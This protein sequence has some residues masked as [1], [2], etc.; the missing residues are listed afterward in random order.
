MTNNWR[1]VPKFDSTRRERLEQFN[2]FDK[3]MRIVSATT[4]VTGA[5]VYEGEDL[6]P[7]NC[8]RPVVSLNVTGE[9]FDAFF[10]SPGG[11]RAQYLDDPEHGQAANNRLLRLL[12]PRLTAAIVEE[13]RESR[14]TRE[15]L[16]KAFLANSAK[17]WPNEEELDPLA[18]NIDLAVERWQQGCDCVVPK[19]AGLWAPEGSSLKVFGAFIDPY[20]NEIVSRKKILRR[21][22][23][24]ECG[25]S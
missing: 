22:D 7:S 24:H 17:I 25:F 9:A 20:G 4:Q 6:G 5:W 10:N 11:Y 18:L 2:T 14:L 13:C 12:E 19:D 3:V 1:F 21:F 16:R 15:L 8:W 23:I